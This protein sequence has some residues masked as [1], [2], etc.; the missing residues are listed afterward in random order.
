MIKHNWIGQQA[1]P[2][3][4]AY[5]GPMLVQQSWFCRPYVV[6]QVQIGL[7]LALH[8][9]PTLQFNVGPTLFHQKHVVLAQHIRVKIGPTF[10]WKH[11]PNVYMRV[12]AQRLHESISPTFTWKYWPNIQNVKLAL[13]LCWILI[14][15]RMH[16]V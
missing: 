14:F 15:S 1:L 5:V 8:V 6:C 16:H 12:L 13:A 10:T 11:W 9:G 7:T 3:Q 4:H 2:R